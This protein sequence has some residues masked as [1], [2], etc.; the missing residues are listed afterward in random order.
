[1]RAQLLGLGGLGAGASEGGD[2]ASPGG[3]ELDG[4]VAEAAD[5]DD[6]GAGGG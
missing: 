6:A 4:H 5:A 1:M 3:E 2:V